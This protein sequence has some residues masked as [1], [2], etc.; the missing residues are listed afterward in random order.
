[1]EQPRYIWEASAYSIAKAI[2]S[3]ISCKSGTFDNVSTRTQ[4][5]TNLDPIDEMYKSTCRSFVPFFQPSGKAAEA[6]LCAY[7]DPIHIQY[8]FLDWE[9]ARCWFEHVMC[10]KEGQ[11]CTDQ[12]AKIFIYMI[13]AI[14]TQLLDFRT[15][16]CGCT[17]TF[18][19]KAFR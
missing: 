16:I 9:E 19:E 5:V 15:G 8:P 17:R 4:G 13:F 1:M 6:Y 3:S 14:G 2:A 12:N 10:L 18:Y 7:H 11:E